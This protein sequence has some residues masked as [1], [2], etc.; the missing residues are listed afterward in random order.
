M[1]VTPD[2]FY[3]A[4]R[5]TSATEVL[6]RAETI[7]REGGEIIDIGGCST[8]PGSALISEDE[9][10]ARLEPALRLL[11]DNFNHAIV[12]VDTFRSSIARRAVEDYGAAIIN[13]V[14]GGEFDS[15]MFRLIAQ[16]NVPY[17]LMHPEVS[18][19]KASNDI[20]G[21][22]LLYLAEKLRLLNSLG[23]NDVI[24]DPGFGFGKTLDE[25]Y[26]LM[27][28]L[29]ELSDM[30]ECPLLVGVSRKRMVYNL[31]GCNAEDSL[32]GTTALNTFALLHG[33][34]IL[35][36]HDVKAAV[37]A[38]IITDKLKTDR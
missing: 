11:R 18:D 10:W 14:S 6:S 35:R 36:V 7:L 19:S 3:A 31:L 34:D 26:E 16:L 29:P 38:V 23:V 4:S 13:D 32:N 27:R 28:R 5:L 30:L 21:N 24:I 12:S 9:E 8:R 20:A 37:Q 17:V 25:N 33:A 1:N 15:E 22:V 2:S